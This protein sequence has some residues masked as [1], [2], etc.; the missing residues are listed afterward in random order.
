LWSAQ[1]LDRSLCRDSTIKKASEAANSGRQ[2][3]KFLR[4]QMIAY[5]QQRAAR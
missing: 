3:F 5:S 1:P 2:A 4:F